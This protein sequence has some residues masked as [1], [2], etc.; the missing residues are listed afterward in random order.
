MDT[1]MIARS[2]QGIHK[3]VLERALLGQ[4]HQAARRGPGGPEVR[5]HRGRDLAE[6]VAAPG[7]VD[8]E[9]LVLERP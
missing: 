1:G 2:V 7:R 3:A 4:W 9:R 8:V 5:A 6:H